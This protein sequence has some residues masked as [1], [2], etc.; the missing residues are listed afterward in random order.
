MALLGPGRRHQ[1]VA[2]LSDDPA[3]GLFGPA[4]L[5][6]PSERLP[7]DHP[8]ASGTLREEVDDVAGRLGAAPARLQC[9]TRAPPA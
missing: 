4:H 5:L 3:L 8:M 1:I 2:A 7:E 6:V 9:P